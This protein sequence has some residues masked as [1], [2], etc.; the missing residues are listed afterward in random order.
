STNL[1]EDFPMARAVLLAVVLAAGATAQTESARLQFEVAAIRPSAPA[2]NAQARGGGVPI[3]GAQFR[4]VGVSR[5]NCVRA[6]CTILASLISGPDWMAA[7]KFDITATLPPGTTERQ[8]N[9]MMQALLADRFLLKVH[10][11]RKEFPVYALIV[12]KDGLK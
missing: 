2:A 6:A 12:D 1:K 8:T 9:A 4:A 5:S 3:D 7:E 10:R 11:E